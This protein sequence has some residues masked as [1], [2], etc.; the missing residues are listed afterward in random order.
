MGNKTRNILFGVL[1][2][3]VLVVLVILRQT[4]TIPTPSTTYAPVTQ[5]TPAETVSVSPLASLSAAVTQTTTTKSSVGDYAK[6]LVCKFFEEPHHDKFTVIS[7]TDVSEWFQGEGVWGVFGLFTGG[8]TALHFYATVEKQK[9]GDWW[10]LDFSWGVGAAPTSSETLGAAPQAAPS[11]TARQTTTTESSAISVVKRSI[12]TVS[13]SG[14][15]YETGDLQGGTAVLV[16]DLAAY[17]VKGE[18]VYAANRFAKTLSPDVEYSPTGI[19][20]DTVS[21]AC[22]LAVDWT[23]C[24]RSRPTVTQTTRTRSSAMDHARVLVWKYLG[25][26]RYDL[27]TI[28]RASNTSADIWDVSGRFAYVG[29]PTRTF[30][31]LIEKEPTGDW[32][33]FAFSWT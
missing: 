20:L 3:V 14:Q 30:D 22:G 23:T 28:T 29:G 6:K 26:P 12:T 4:E 27:L 11:S 13:T 10:L 17:W 2:L 15:T 5:S 31:A 32:S 33:L 16:D 25:E 21:A 8:S 18:T 7:V 9:N 1:A 19:D 24:P